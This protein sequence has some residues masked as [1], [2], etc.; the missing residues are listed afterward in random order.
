MKITV[1]RSGA[2]D[3]IYIPVCIAGALAALFLFWQDL[4]QTLLRQN[5]KPIGTVTWKRRAAQRRF[6]DR[7]LW[8]RLRRESPVYSGDFIRTAAESSA[9]VRFSGTGNQEDPWE[10]VLEINENT[11]IQVIRTSSGMDIALDSGGV[12]VSSGGGDM[13]IRSGEAVIDAG[14]GSSLDAARTGTGLE[15]QV[16]GGSAGVREGGESKTLGQGE[17]LVS[18]GASRRVMVSGLKNQTTI[19]NPGGALTVP[20]DWSTG[21][22]GRNEKLI[23]DIARD[24]Q[25]TRI[26]S[27]VKSSTGGA[28][29]ENIVLENG[30]Y[31]W[32][33]YPE[34]QGGADAKSVSGRIEVIAAP[35]PRLLR[36]LEG[37][38]FSFTTEKPGI[39]FA[40]TSGEGAV[41]YLVETAQNPGMTGA[42]RSVEVQSTGAGSHSAVLTGFTPGTWYWRVTPVYPGSYQGSPRQSA[43]A[44][45]TVTAAFALAAPQVRAMP[46]KRYLEDEKKSYF[47]W[48]QEAGAAYYTFLLSKEKDLSSPVIEDRAENNYYVL[49]S[50]GA[51]SPGEY[52]W[53]VY[54]T[55]AEGSRSPVSAARPLVVAAGV[56]PAPASRTI[57]AAGTPGAGEAP[58]ADLSAGRDTAAE[59]PAGPIPAPRYLEPAA[60]S[61]ITEE[62]LF[63]NRRI[64]FTWRAEPEAASYIFRLYHGGRLLL[65]R[66]VSEPSFTLTQLALLDA[67]DFTWQVES[68]G[69]RNGETAESRFTISSGTA[70]VQVQE[71]GIMFG[72]D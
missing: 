14:A 39:R 26:I 62:T 33:A 11:L 2:A 66:E 56:P 37:E 54:Q 58:G 69:N 65:S 17:S 16:T 1:R 18:G 21:G 32:R 68:R 8:D 27:S 22:S 29:S 15:L 9:A 28:G 25:F 30:V 35:A 72:N 12:S 42:V 67:G 71:S 44:S 53:G 64:R 60:G 70:E 52:Y 5:E 4:N 23:I 38:S 6:P 24:R 49:E 50:G 10:S 51:L 46:E 48:Q 41:S 47:V 31:Y 59:K 55:D 36:P 45:F 19:L 43:A 20:V 34:S 3:F 13:R 57:G 40:W 63:Q 7:A 61:L